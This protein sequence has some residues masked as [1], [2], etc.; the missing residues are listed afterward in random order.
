MTHKVVQ[1]KPLDQDTILYHANMNGLID[2]MNYDV[3]YPYYYVP[4]GI[5]PDM[6]YQFAN[7]I[8]KAQNER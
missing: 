7:D 5:T 2:Y 3:P 8:L 4:Q 1:V 6:I